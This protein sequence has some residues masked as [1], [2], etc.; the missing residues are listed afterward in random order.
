[1]ACGS[2]VLTT[3]ELS[4]PEVG[5]DAVEY[6]GT[7]APS[8]ARGLRELL[9]APDRRAALGRAAVERAAGFTWRA[10]ALVHVEAFEAALRRTR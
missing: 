7:D 10:A 6:C 9:A 8:I 1:M 2:A 4:L 3:R 5:G